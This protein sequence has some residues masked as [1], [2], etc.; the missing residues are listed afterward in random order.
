VSN[1]FKRGADLEREL[2]R[3][4]PEP[5]TEFLATMVERVGR[6]RR[7]TTQRMRLGFA[8]ALTAMIVVSLGAFGGL[9]YAASA[10]Q[11]VAHVVTK[12]VTPS[13]PQPV[14]QLSS[15]ASAQYPKKEVI[16]HFDGQ[17]RGHTI[18]IDVSAFPAHRAHG[19]HLG[20][21]KPGEFRPNSK[22]AKAAAKKKAAKK[23]VLGTSQTG[24]N[25][26]STG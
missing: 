11:S 2:R 6:E 15:S 8:G 17:G 13:K 7:S 4:R 21:C 22:A 5:R 24:V 1:F 26:S 18:T 25:P 3:N 12:V 9:G 16:C 14:K 20:A 10:V 19:D 23:G